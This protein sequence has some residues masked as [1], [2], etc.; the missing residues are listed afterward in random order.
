MTPTAKSYGKLGCYFPKKCRSGLVLCPVY[1]NNIL[2]D[3]EFDDIKAGMESEFRADIFLMGHSGSH[4]NIKD[5]GDFLMGIPFSDQL[6]DLFLAVRKPFIG[7][8]RGFTFLSAEKSFHDTRGHRGTV[9]LKSAH[10]PC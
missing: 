3:G 4:G 10:S 8:F 5:I 1:F 2:F 7:S 9:K 6:Q